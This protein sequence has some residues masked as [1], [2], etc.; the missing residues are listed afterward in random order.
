MIDPERLARAALCHYSMP[1]NSKVQGWIDRDGAEKAWAI[2]QDHEKQAARLSQVDPIK[3][4]Q[5]LQAVGGRLLCPGDD[6]WPNALEVLSIHQDPTK[7][8][9]PY[10][11]WVR[12]KGNLAELTEHSVS[13]VGSR[14]ATDYGSY[15]AS[16]IASELV[17]RG[18]SVISGGAHG[19]DAAAHRGSLAADGVTIAVLANGVDIAYPAAH[20]LLFGRIMEKGCIISELPPGLGVR[21]EQFLHRNRII[22]ALSEA[23]VVVEAGARSGA[24]S[25]AR[26]A[27]RLLREVFAVPGPITSAMSAGCH[28]LLREGYARLVTSAEEI[29]A[30]LGPLAPMQPKLGQVT[31]RDQLELI[32]RQVLDGFPPYSASSPVEIAEAS[33]L[34]FTTV[35]IELEGLLEAG[36]VEIASGGFRLSELARQPSGH[37]GK[38]R[39]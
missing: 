14:A 34:A 13:M 25:T 32:A 28:E 29:A 36:F 2:A 38:G 16:T 7:A 15:V 23:T 3:D 35:V 26:H 12:G 31:E 37:P 30:E 11:L 1:G 6:E 19:I 5:R 10:A 9:L 24:L 20:D 33:G 22:A 27:M 8:G 21:R 4:L 39:R 18:W 17:P